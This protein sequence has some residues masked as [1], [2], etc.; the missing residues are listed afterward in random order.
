VIRAQY[1]LDAAVPYYVV[2]VGGRW[3]ED[4]YDRPSSFE[5]HARKGIR[6]LKRHFSLSKLSD[7]RVVPY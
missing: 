1:D 6:V 7:F 2:Y 3:G 4:V 5:L